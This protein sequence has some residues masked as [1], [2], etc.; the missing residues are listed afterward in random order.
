MSKQG[1]KS[2]NPKY[3]GP[4]L[5]A[6]TAIELAWRISWKIIRRIYRKSPRYMDVFSAEFSFP[7]LP[8]IVWRQNSPEL[9]NSI[10]GKD[11]ITVWEENTPTRLINTKSVRIFSQKS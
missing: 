8:E 10:L 3:S 4:N 1:R 9:I 11:T 5:L 2:P 7:S 6:L